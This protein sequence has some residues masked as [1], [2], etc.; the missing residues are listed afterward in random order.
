MFLVSSLWSHEALCSLH[1]AVALRFRLCEMRD[2]RSLPTAFGKRRL[3]V[4]GSSETRFKQSLFPFFGMLELELGVGR[5]ELLC[6]LVK[7]FSLAGV[8]IQFFQR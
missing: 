2:G 6:A 8:R 5:R 3:F 4:L 1:L 7:H